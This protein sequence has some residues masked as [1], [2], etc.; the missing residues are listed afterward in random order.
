MKRQL[1][2][3]EVQDVLQKLD[4]YLSDLKSRWDQQNPGNRSW[5]TVPRNYILKGT[6][7]IVNVLDELITFVEPIIPNGG[8]KK[9]AVLAICDKLF[10]YII[11][12]S[13]PFWLKPFSGAIKKIVVEI[14]L[15]YLIDFIVD[16]YNSGY[17]SIKQEA[18]NGTTD[19]I[20]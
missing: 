4:L 8:D 9:A 11:T 5:F 3:S 20:A 14:L 7:F 13:F 1:T 2:T 18:I 17:W 10:D 6:I 16:K 19:Q 12:Q 15:S